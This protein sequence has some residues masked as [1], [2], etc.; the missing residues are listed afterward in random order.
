MSKS[1]FTLE[2]DKALF[3][4][5][6][7][8][9]QFFRICR[10]LHWWCCIG[11]GLLPT[12][13]PRLV[14]ETNVIDSRVAVRTNVLIEVVANLAICDCRSVTHLMGCVGGSSVMAMSEAAWGRGEA[15][16]G[17]AG[18]VSSPCKPPGSSQ[19][20]PSGHSRWQTLPG[21]W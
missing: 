9:Q 6:N 10:I 17:E 4:L 16:A 2:P 18:G 11:K 19:P 20:P 21:I 3:S 5:R 15:E 12:G 7:W 13:P 1:M 8:L 14:L